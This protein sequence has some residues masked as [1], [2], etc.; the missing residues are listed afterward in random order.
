M[1]V[2]GLNNILFVPLQVNKYIQHQMFQDLEAR[3]LYR[4]IAYVVAE[5][6]LTSNHAMFL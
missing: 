6:L 4:V 1:T 5:V 3:S 2:V